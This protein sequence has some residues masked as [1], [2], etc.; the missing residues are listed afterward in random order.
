M[1]K[2]FLGLT[3]LLTACAG[4]TEIHGSLVKPADVDRLRVGVDTQQ[5]VMRLLGTPST[6][7]TL[8]EEKWFYITDIKVTKPLT[9][10]KLKERQ[11]V[12]LV[13]N[14]NGILDRVFEKT[15]IESKQFTPEQE[16][17]ATQGQKMGVTDQIL[18]NLTSGLKK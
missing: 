5:R 10:P 6:I 4:T 17:T 8:N 15:E 16:T 13:F 14:K 1:K 7:S 9:K 11:I 18:L 3:L 12:G 2:A